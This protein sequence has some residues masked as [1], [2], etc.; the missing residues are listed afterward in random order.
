[1]STLNGYRQ[2]L[3]TGV[4]EPA[5][6]VQAAGEQFE[7]DDGVD[8]DD[9]YDEQRNVEQRH[10]SFEYRVQ[11]DLKTCATNIDRLFVY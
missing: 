3:P 9:E 11:N 8:D 6:L 5:G 4:V 10:H 7:A 1:M 2:L